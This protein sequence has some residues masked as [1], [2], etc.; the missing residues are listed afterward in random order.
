MKN[1][2]TLIRTIC[3]GAIG[4]FLLILLFACSAHRGSRIAPPVTDIDI[5]FQ[6]HRFQADSGMQIRL[7][8]G[9]Q[10]R[11]EPGSLVDA[12][13]NLVRGEVEF[14]VREFHSTN[15]MLRSGIPLNTQRNGSD[16][17]QSAGMIEMRAFANDQVLEVAEGKTI[18]VDLAG[19]RN[20]S[21]YDLWY[22]EGDDNWKVRG[23]YRSDSNRY[24]IEAIRTLSDSLKKPRSP[25]EEEDR[26]FELVGNITEIPYLK[27]YAGMKWRLDDSEKIEV[28]GIQGRVHWENVRINKVKNRQQVYA[29]TFTQFDRGEGSSESGIQKTILASPMTTRG[30]MKKRMA[31]YEKEVAEVERRERERQEALALAKREADLVQSFRADRMGIWNVD[32]FQKMED[33]VPVYV[34]FDFEKSIKS[35]DRPIRLFALYD[36][37]NSV[38]EYAPSD[39]KAVYLQKGKS[40]RLIALLPNDQLALVDNEKIQPVLEQ[41][42]TEV[43]FETKRFSAKEF[44][45]MT[46][47]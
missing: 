19:Y 4:Y 14:R 47:P 6:K 45:K 30:D 13:G 11:I 29:L 15:D 46:T 41:G 44:L 18:G 2:L 25:Q 5:P 7:S 3:L 22:M 27:P 39:W 42:K 34:R 10:I 31:I 38:M 12:K 16:R 20:S 24:K 23:N 21:G 33:C 28:L 9:T 1:S 43:S 32:R 8:S 36:G 26:T 17:L 40:M 35:G 37:D